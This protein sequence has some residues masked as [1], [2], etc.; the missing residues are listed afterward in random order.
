MRNG[1]VRFRK[2]KTCNPF[3]PA[4]DDFFE[5]LGLKTSPRHKIKSF[6]NFT[7]IELKG[8]IS[9]RSLDNLATSGVMP[10]TVSR[11]GWKL[12][13]FILQKK[14]PILRPRDMSPIHWADTHIF[15]MQFITGLEHGQKI[16]EIDPLF[17]LDFS[18]IKAFLV[19]RNTHYQ[20]QI[21]MLKKY[22]KEKDTL[23]G[24]FILS[25]YQPVIPHTC[26]SD[27][28]KKL[29][30][31]ALKRYPDIDNLNPNMLEVLFLF[32]NDFY[33]SIFSVIDFT[34]IEYF[35]RYVKNTNYDLS[36]NFSWPQNGYI[37]EVMQQEGKCYFGRFMAFIKKK[38]GKSYHALATAIQVDFRGETENGRTLHEAQVD[39][40]KDWRAG[41][42]QPTITTLS[43]FFDNLNLN[44][45]ID[46]AIYGKLFQ[47][48][49][50]YIYFHSS[51]FDEP[52]NAKQLLESVFSEKYYKRH[53]QKV[54]KLPVLA[55]LD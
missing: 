11:I 36:S 28:E 5:F 42:T 50:R 34:Y 32:L 48:I 19:Q 26:L 29:L 39:T 17:H 16:P 13:R 18:Y 2:L 7:G 10:K 8:L 6:L 44:F 21:D 25:F 40:L 14:I 53:Y 15:W 31:E 37:S 35:K 27:Q 1:K 3:Y 12:Y 33:L 41:K 4:P 43:T 52:E 49:D 22:D 54:E 20:P 23:N 38:S 9:D 45:G 30:V 24:D 55:A 47:S 46:C 51:Q